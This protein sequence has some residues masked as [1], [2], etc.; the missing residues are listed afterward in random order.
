MK[1]SL[2]DIESRFYFNL[3][4]WKCETQLLSTSVYQN[5]YF[6]EIVDMGTAVVPFILKELKNGDISLVPALD[7]IFPNVLKY[8]GFVSLKE[9]S[10]KWIFILNKEGI[11]SWHG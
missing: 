5:K 9:A 11:E 1:S 3:R 2:D 8:D 10:D 6:K 7:E 4:Q